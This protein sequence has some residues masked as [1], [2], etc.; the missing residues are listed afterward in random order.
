MTRI[1]SVVKFECESM[2]AAAA[3]A[4]SGHD[5]QVCEEAS[6]LAHA[7]HAA[8]ASAEG[9]CRALSTADAGAAR[10][11]TVWIVDED[12][13][14]RVYLEDLLSVN[15]LSVVTFEDSQLAVVAAL[16]DPSKIGI[17]VT[18]QRLSIP[19]SERLLRT[20]RS[21]RPDVSVIVCTASGDRTSGAIAAEFGI[22]HLLRRPFDSRA[23]LR[24]VNGNRDL[25]RARER[26][27]GCPGFLCR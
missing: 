9:D 26:E 23:L 13:I 11:R 3:M 27:P 15:G 8:A 21:L 24:A 4:A 25:R 19:S 10:T 12:P 7:P 1:Q 17:V 2:P 5:R 6:P 18:G 22:R 16:A 20:I 14:A